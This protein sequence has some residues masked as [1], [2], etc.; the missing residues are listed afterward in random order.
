MDGD[1][2][3]RARL[4]ITPLSFLHQ[5]AVLSHPPVKSVH[6]HINGG[7]LVLTYHFEPSISVL[8]QI[9]FDAQ[10]NRLGSTIKLLI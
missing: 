1:F 8:K 2:L 4:P 10:V 6:S 7:E 9:S 3:V 5:T